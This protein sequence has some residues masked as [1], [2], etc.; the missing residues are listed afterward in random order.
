MRLNQDTKRFVAALGMA[1]L[2]TGL[3]LLASWTGVV[4]FESAARATKFLVMTTS[5]LI[6][7]VFVAGIAGKEYS[8]SD[9]GLN[10]S[11][12]SLVSLIAL[13][14]TSSL[15]GGANSEL[16]AAMGIALCLMFF[17]LYL[18]AEAQRLQRAMPPLH[19]ALSLAAGVVATEVYILVCLSPEIRTWQL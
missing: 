12:L 4:V 18:A 6:G 3:W 8:F 10:L 2:F 14:A 9:H 1:V 5:L 17:A 11:T 19:R 7:E 16:R 15:G 13:N